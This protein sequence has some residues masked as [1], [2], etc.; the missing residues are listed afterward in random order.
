MTKQSVIRY[1]NCNDTSVSYLNSCFLEFPISH[2]WSCSSRAGATVHTGNLAPSTTWRHSHQPI[3]RYSRA[4]DASEAHGGWGKHTVSLLLH[5]G[6]S[7]RR[8]TDTSHSHP[9]TLPD[10]RGKY[11]QKEAHCYINHGLVNK[12]R[13]QESVLW[14]VLP[15]FLQ[16]F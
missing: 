6:K 12:N 11:E 1:Y 16:I 15:R 10:D 4:L 14:N 3:D 7:W 5:V 9:Q 13:T 8:L 2:N